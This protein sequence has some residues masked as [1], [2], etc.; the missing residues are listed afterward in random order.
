MAKRARKNWT[1]LGF[2]IA[3]GVS[4]F[5]A[6]GI[7]TLYLSAPEERIE[8]FGLT[9]L[10]DG[11]S[12]DPDH[13]MTPLE[14]A[15]QRFK[16]EYRVDRVSKTPPEISGTKLMMRA[17]SELNG[18]ERQ[19][20]IDDAVRLLRKHPDSIRQVF[21]LVDKYLSNNEHLAP[22]G[23][24]VKTAVAMRLQEE[25]EDRFGFLDN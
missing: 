23:A 11:P 19:L 24:E 18:R 10:L 2:V 5:L 14:E 9:G 6:V 13:V 16:E 8:K 22:L 3:G 17:I 15:R 25:N 4:A 12:S 1:R 20:K 21:A 7:G